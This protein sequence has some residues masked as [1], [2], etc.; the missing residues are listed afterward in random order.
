[1]DGRHDWLFQWNILEQIDEMRCIRDVIE[2][3][4]AAFIPTEFRFVRA[5]HV[6]ERTEA[7]DDFGRDVGLPIGAPL[8]HFLIFVK[9]SSKVLAMK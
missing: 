5:C 8:L 4:E 6:D 1:M 9:G 2:V 3:D 7:G